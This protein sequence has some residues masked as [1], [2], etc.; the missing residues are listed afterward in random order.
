MKAVAVI[1]GK[2]S[3]DRDLCNNCGRC[4]ESCYFDVIKGYTDC[5]KVFVGGRWGKTVSRGI[6][7]DRLYSLDEISDVM[8]KAILLYKSEGLPGERFGQVCERLGMLRVNELFDGAELLSKKDA[9]L[10]ESNNT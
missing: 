4:V 9:I 3:V 7:L 2:I 10:N 5:L 8:E 1:E 6:P